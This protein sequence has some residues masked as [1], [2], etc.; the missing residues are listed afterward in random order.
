MSIYI[1][2]QNLVPLHCSFIWFVCLWGHTFHLWG[3]VDSTV[4]LLHHN[5]KCGH[6][7]LLKILVVSYYINVKNE[8]Y[9]NGYR[10]RSCTCKTAK[11]HCFVTFVM[12]CFI[13]T[14]LEAF[15]WACRYDTVH[16]KC[17]ETVNFCFFRCAT[18]SP[19]TVFINFVYYINIC[20]FFYS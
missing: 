10:R 6:I 16:Y 9:K 5:Q 18:T 14:V 11:I 19:I 2:L 20:C 4:D 1:I 7:L 8:V 13:T 12:Y 15:Y 17:D 3:L